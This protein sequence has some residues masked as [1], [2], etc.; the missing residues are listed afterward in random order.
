MNSIRKNFAYNSF[1]VV[2]ERVITLIL[3]PYCTRV[4]GVEKFGTVNFA[5]TIVQYFTFFAVMGVATIG[6]REIAKQRDKQG[7]NECFSSMIVLSSIFTLITLLIYVPLIF[8]IDKLQVNKELY[9]FGGL[10]ILFSAFCIEWFYRGIEDFKY[11]TIRSFSIRLI[12][13]LLVF[14]FV[15]ESS[16]YTTFFYLTVWMVVANSIVNY[17][18]ARRHVSLKLSGINWRKYF[19]SSLTLG[20]YSILTSMYTTFNVVYLGFAWDDTQVGLYTTA[21]KMYIIVLGFYSAFTGVML[22]RMSSVIADSDMERFK[23]LIQKSLE[24]LYVFSFPMIVFLFVMSPEIIYVLAGEE[25]MPAVLLSRI[26]VP[27]LFVVGLAQVFSFQIII[28]CG[29]DNVTFKAA[30]IGAIAGIFL[31][32]WLTTQ[33]S[34]IGTCLTVVFT[35]LIVTSYYFYVVRA[36]HLMTFEI[37]DI[38]RHVLYSLPYIL[39]CVL[40]KLYCDNMFIN[41]GLASVFCLVYFIISQYYFIKNENFL[42]MVNRLGFNH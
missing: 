4:L 6:A 39:I 11:I 5:Q 29:L 25:F 27:M 13:V 19:K 34:A 18:F 9:L 40:T 42:L 14:I 38:V 12:Y 7:L 28:P 33:Y 30:L 16:D 8:F 37:R 20:A 10:Q 32:L 21:I 2:S 41:L 35:E 3:F 1:L 15:R 26:V 23:S 22:P 17:W 31:N 36:K 24:L